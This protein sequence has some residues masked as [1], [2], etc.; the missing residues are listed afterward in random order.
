MSRSLIDEVNAEVALHHGGVPLRV[1]VLLKKMPPAFRR[2]AEKVLAGPY[3]AS[4]VATV[5]TKH[6]YKV[7]G[8]AII[9]WRKRDQEA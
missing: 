1:G 7:S 2:E 8:A 9:R 6:G 4:V 5:L 3:S